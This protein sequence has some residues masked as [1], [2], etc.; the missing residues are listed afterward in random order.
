MVSAQRLR[1]TLGIFLQRVSKVSSMTKIS[2]PRI[3][4]CRARPSTQKSCWGPTTRYQPEELCCPCMP[5]SD[6]LLGH[7]EE[8]WK[9]LLGRYLPRTCFGLLIRS[10]RFWPF[11]A[12]GLACCKR[13]KPHP[14]VSRWCISA[15]ADPTNCQ[16]GAAPRMQTVRWTSTQRLAPK[17]RRWRRE[18][19][20]RYHGPQCRGP[21]TTAEEQ[22]PITEAL[23]LAQPH[24]LWSPHARAAPSPS[25]SPPPPAQPP[26]R[27]PRPRPASPLP[28]LASA[29]LRC[30]ASSWSSG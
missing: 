2:H 4:T 12:T 26:R 9:L 22:Q 8:S 18:G 13:C 21:E 10:R 28:A 3:R 29:W 14:H 11:C 19:R 6:A 7:R 25:P 20:T 17:H 30:E 5:T 1:Q 27:A 15:S 23:T 16:A 24:L